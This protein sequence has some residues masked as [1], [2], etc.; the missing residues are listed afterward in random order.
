MKVQHVGYARKSR[1]GRAL[2]LDL[3]LLKFLTAERYTGKDGKEYVGLVVN[4]STLLD[5]LEGRREVTGVNQISIDID[6]EKSGGKS[7]NGKK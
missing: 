2:K 7:G 5:V 4:M 3:S 6:K 1:N